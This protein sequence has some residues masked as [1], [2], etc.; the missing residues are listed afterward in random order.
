MKN[1]VLTGFMGSGKTTVGSRVAKRFGMKVVD[2]DDLIEE[3][4]C[5]SIN[6]I[7]GQ[8]GEP[9]F[10]ELEKKIVKEVSE[11]E[12]YVILTGGGVVL[13]KENMNNLRRNGIIVYLHVSPEDAYQR[14]KGKSNRPL[15]KVEDPL[16]KIRELLEYRAPFYAD[17]DVEIDTTGL[18]VDAVAR[19]VMKRVKPLIGA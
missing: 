4:T 11:L 19:E 7:F 2:T 5:M 3:R 6:D 18:T 13:N 12:G 9:Y 16:N 14:L 1:I 15:L 17:N 10:R 8:R